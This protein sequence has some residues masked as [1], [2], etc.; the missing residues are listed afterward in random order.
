MS[1]CCED[2]KYE[3]GEYNLEYLEKLDK[4]LKLHRHCIDEDGDKQKIIQNIATE[5]VINTDDTK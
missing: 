5:V 4:F 1:A 2:I 3:K